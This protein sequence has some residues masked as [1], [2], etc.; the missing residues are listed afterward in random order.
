MASPQLIALHQRANAG[1]PEAVAFTAVVAALG[2]GERP[3][4]SRALDRL[5]RAAKL[6]SASAEGQLAV[7][8][9]SGFIGPPRPI[10][11]HRLLADPRITSLPGFLP[12][13][14]CEWLVG[15]AAGHTRLAETYDP[16]TGE[17]HVDPERNNSAIGFA[18]PAFDLVI[19]AIRARIATAIG[20]PVQRL[21]PAQ[22]LH[23][24]PGQQFGR[25]HD[26]LDPDLPGLAAEVASR[27]QRVATFLIYLNS[28]FEGG[29]TDFPLVGVTYKGEPG[30][31]L[32]FANVDRA[33][34]PD[35]RTLHA[36]LPPRSGEKWLFSQ[37]IRNRTAI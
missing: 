16:K 15:R 30:D 1:D 11:E 24:A 22:V 2:V 27:G 3:S 33:G 34:G 31:G 5:K 20:A 37:W 23:Y 18:F 28:G 13:P 36:G 4:W 17:R 25:H 29:E 35:R 7:L 26:F 12:A 21:E 14:A 9:A 8:E 32:T 10:K 6:G 19:V